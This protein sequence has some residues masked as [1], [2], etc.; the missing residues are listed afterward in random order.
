MIGLCREYTDRKGIE[1]YEYSLFS[2][3]GEDGILRYIFSEIGIASKFFFEFGFGV[4][5]NNSARLML[6][7]DFDGVFV[8]GSQRTVSLF[9]RCAESF[10]LRNVRA[11]TQFLNRENLED[12][13]S[14]NNIPK[15]LDLLSID[16]DGNDYWFWDCIDSIKAR[17]VVIEYNASLGPDLSLSVVYDPDFDRHAK[18]DSGFY[19]GA[20]LAALTT[21]GKRKGYSLVGCDSNGVNAFFV[22]NDCMNE[23]LKSLTPGMAFH[24]HKGRLKRGFSQQEQFN[25]ICEMPFVE[26]T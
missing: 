14:N 21:L 11:V 12:I 9:N 25:T 7:D 17:V 18:H 26:I 3:N 19:C 16:V 22:R 6:K 1:R 4:L 23:N 8:D 10:G 24:S 20:S 15:E 13:I 5:Q 2:Q